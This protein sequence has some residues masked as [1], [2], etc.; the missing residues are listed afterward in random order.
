MELSISFTKDTAKYVQIYE[1][2]K[3]AIINKK[4]LCP[5]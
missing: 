2:I 4:T 5:G 3:V 1:E